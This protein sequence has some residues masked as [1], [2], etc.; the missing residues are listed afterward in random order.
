[1]VVLKCAKCG[2]VWAYRGTRLYYATCPQCFAQVK[3]ANCQ[4]PPEEAEKVLEER[5]KKRRR[6]RRR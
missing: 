5:K 6:R 1:M 2:Y 4:L 3:L